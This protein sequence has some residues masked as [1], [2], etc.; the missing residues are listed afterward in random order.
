MNIIALDQEIKGIAAIVNGER[1]QIGTV[2]DL[3][4]PPGGGVIV[5]DTNVWAVSNGLSQSQYCFDDLN[6]RQKYLD[7]FADDGYKSISISTKYARGLY[8]KRG[9][10]QEDAVQALYDEVE[11][12]IDRNGRF[13]SGRPVRETRGDI[14]F[15]MRDMV[16]LDFLRIQNSGGY[17]SDFLNNAVEIAWNSLDK[18]GKQLF[19]LKIRTPETNSPNRLAAVL[20][21]THNPE[22]GLRREYNGKPWGKRFITRRI[23]CL[24]GMMQGTG[25]LSPG[26]PMRAVLRILGRRWGDK[27]NK[28]ERARLDWYVKQLIDV[29]QKHEK[30]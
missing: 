5:A 12:Q 29:F 1:I 14:S 27:I 20:V 26:S 6:D 18:E 30:I 2:K 28:E 15:G 19:N 23:L 11:D 10:T 8:L 22:D 24:N 3:Q 16:T 21:C 7:S 13:D 17:D 9:Y 25:N 4:L